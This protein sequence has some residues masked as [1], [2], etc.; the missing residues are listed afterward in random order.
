MVV[1]REEIAKEDKN[2]EKGMQNMKKDE[3]EKSFRGSSSGENRTGQ[4]EPSKVVSMAQDSVSPALCS[5][6]AT[7]KLTLTVLL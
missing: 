1:N 7:A 2:G 3:E 6:T 4:W 5:L